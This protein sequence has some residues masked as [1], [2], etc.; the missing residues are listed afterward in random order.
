M[1]LYHCIKSVFCSPINKYIPKGAVVYK[2]E[3]TSKI[4]IQGAPQSDS[5]Y[6]IELDNFE[7]SGAEQT[8]WFY[9]SKMFDQFFEF[10]KDVPEDE[11]GGGAG[12][13]G[14]SGQGFPMQIDTFT[15]DA[16]DLFEGCIELTKPIIIPSG[17]SLSVDGAPGQFLG[18]DFTVDINN[19]TVCWTGYELENKLIIGD[20]LTVIYTA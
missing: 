10:V 5:T 8:S 17:V 9:K 18:I 19:N 11:A 3:K 13:S 1:K 7:F 6:G 15:L 20:K 2:Y 16:V 14:A 4:S 12:G